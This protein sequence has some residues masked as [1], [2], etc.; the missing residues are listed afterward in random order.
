VGRAHRTGTAAPHPGRAGPSA[1]GRE[2][3]KIEAI[4]KPFKLDDVK[5]A[6]SALGVGGMTVIDV[7]CSGHQPSRINRYEGAQYTIDLL[8]RTK[9]EVVVP[10][11]LVDSVV[12]S[13]CETAR[14]GSVG[15]GKVFV[16]P[17]AEAIRIRT[18]ETGEKAV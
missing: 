6:L 12:S 10:D 3:Q 8:S 5:Q 7:R 17:V 18:G 2:L 16:L 15:D 14:T 4:I 11:D 1:W 9:V 13:I